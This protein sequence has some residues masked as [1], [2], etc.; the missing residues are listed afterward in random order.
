MTLMQ[1]KNKKKYVI[2]ARLKSETMGKLINRIPGWLPLVSSLP[3][4]SLRTHVKHAR[5]QEFS[6]AGGGGV[7]VS[8]TKNLFFFS[9]QL[10][11]QKSNG[12]SSIFQGSRGGPTF[13]RGGGVQL[14]PGG[15]NS[16]FPIE[17]HITCDFPGES[18]P[19]VPPSGSALV[20]L[21][22]KPCDVNK[23]SQS[24]AL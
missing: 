16:L 18:G 1:H 11:L 6:S 2:I 14:F 20:K 22:G 24:L 23:P 9:P 15:S 5:I 17:T 8:L 3:G 10:I 21:L 13:S 12:Q 4:S 19:P 7:Q